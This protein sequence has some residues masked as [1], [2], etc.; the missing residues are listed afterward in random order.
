MDDNLYVAGVFEVD[1]E[2]DW[3]IL[4]IFDS[5]EDAEDACVDENCFVGPLVIGPEV[6]D[7]EEIWF[8]ISDDER[9]VKLNICEAEL[10]ELKDYFRKT[11]EKF[12]DVVGECKSKKYKN[13]EQYVDWMHEEIERIAVEFKE[14]FDID[15]VNNR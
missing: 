12:Y 8:P 9:D 10:E 6:V 13:S 3:N 14:Y 7:M 5:I 4:G 15:V 1:S 2:T 11:I